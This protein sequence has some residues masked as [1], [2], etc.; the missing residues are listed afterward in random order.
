MR[1]LILV[2]LTSLALGL[3]CGTEI[4]DSCTF[5][6]E[7]S[8]SGDRICATGTTLPGGYCTIYGCDYDTCP[9][10]AICVKFYAVGSTNVL[11]NPD[12]EDA[13]RFD[14]EGNP[15]GIDVTDDCS[16]EET[17]TLN[18]SCVPRTSETRYCMKK[19]AADGDCRDGYHCR[20]YSLMLQYGGEPV[21]DPDSTSTGI[22]PFCATAP[23]A[24]EEAEAFMS[25]LSGIVHQ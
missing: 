2:S 25:P 6:T 4:G 23:S 13:P 24:T 20:T 16:P 11:C 15:S 1:T 19:C 3:G 21:T 5:S 7:C 22:Q 17:C 12:T 18:G 10:E 8:P 9:D 14:S